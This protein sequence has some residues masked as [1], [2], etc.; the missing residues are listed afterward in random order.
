MAWEKG[1]EKKEKKSER[2]KKGLG[3]RCSPAGVVPTFARLVPI[4][5]IIRFRFKVLF[6]GSIEL[7]GISLVIWLAWGIEF[8]G[9]GR[10]LGWIVVGQERRIG[11]IGRRVLRLR[12]VLWRL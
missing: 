9:I 6:I 4:R 8:G 11:L 10:K 7:F 5:S 12:R 1:K 2:Q 3:E